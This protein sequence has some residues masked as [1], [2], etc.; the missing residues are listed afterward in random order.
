MK[1]YLLTFLLSLFAFISQAQISG[2]KNI[3]GDYA[4]L[5][6]AITALNAS[7]VGSGGVT[8]NVV[9]ANPQTAS[10]AAYQITAT[11]TAANP[12]NIQGNANT[13]TYTGT[14]SA[15]D[16][17][18]VLNGSDYVTV[19]NF[20]ITGDVTTE[21]GVALLTPV[22]NNGA[23]NNTI[24]NCTITLD[25]TNVASIAIYTAHHTNAAV[26][27]LT[28]TSVTGT[29]SNNKFYNNTVQNCYSGYSLTG[30]PAVAPYDLYDQQNEIGTTG[31]GRSQILNFGGGATQAQAVFTV[32]QNKLK[33][34]KTNI[35][36]TGGVNGTGI[37]YGIF[38]NTA[39]NA[40]V[41]IYNDTIT[42]VSIGTTNAMTA[43]NNTAGVTG[44]G[45]TV[46]IY[47]NVV[48]NCTYAT[49]TGATFRGISQSATATYT[50]I[51]NNKVI[52]NSLAGTAEFSGIYYSGSSATLVLNVNINDNEVSNNSKTGTAGILYMISA[53]ANTN[54]TNCYNN[55]VFNNNQNVASTGA[56]YGYYNFGAGYNE[57]VY[58]NQVYNCTGGT[59]ETVALYARS[60][61]GPTIKTVN[62][63]TIYG[64]TG[65]GQV[66]AI[67]SDYATKATIYKNNIYNITSN[68]AATTASVYGIQTGINVNTK[69]DIYNNFISEL[70]APVSTSADAVYGLWLQAGVGI[71]QIN[72]YHNTV[73]LNATSTSAT[74]FGTAVAFLNANP[75]SIDLRNN[76]LVNT[77]TPGPTGGNTVVISRAVTTLS[78]YNLLSG[79]NC[80]YAGIP[81]ANKL[82]FRD[83]TNNDQTLQAFKDRVNPRDQSSFTEL[84]PFINVA[85]SPYNLHLAGTTQCE[86]GGQPITIVTT[87][88]D[89]NIRNVTTPDVGA[90]E[91]TGTMTDIASPN[92][93]YS[94]L[95]NDIIA[96]SRTVNLFA[97]ITDPSAINIT[98]GTNPRL[99]YK[100]KTQSNTYNDNTSAT[101]GWKYVEASNA[102]SAFSF[103]IDYTKLLTGAVVAA[104]TI[105]YF[106]TAQDLAGT[107]LVGLNAGAFTTQPTSVN[108]AAVNFPLLNTINQYG[109]SGNT[110]AGTINVGSAE[111]ITSL[112]NVGGLFQQLKAGV[113]TAD[114]TVNITSDLLLENGQFALVNWNESGAGKYSMTFMP[115]AATVRTIQGLSSSGALI[116]LDSA[117][118]VTFDG[119][120][121]GAGNYIRIRNTNSLNPAILLVNDAQNNTIRNCII[122]SNNTNNATVNIS[123]AINIGNSNIV[124]GSGNDNN[125]ITYNEIR[126]RSDV[127]GTPAI[128]IFSTGSTGSLDLF[129]SNNTISNN[130]IHDFFSATLTV[131]SGIQLGL[132]NTNFN[133]D[134]NSIY[135]TT[136]RVYTTTNVSTRGIFIN[137]S[138]SVNNIG[139]YNIRKN[140]IGGTAPLCGLNG[141]YWTLSS[142]GAITNLFNGMTVATGLLPTV[143]ADNV[144]KNIDYT[145]AA[146]AAATSMFLTLSAN[147][148]K[149]EVNNNQIGAPTGNDSLKLTFNTNGGTNS[150]CFVAGIIAFNG[151]A[152]TSNVTGNKIGG[153]SI[154]GSTTALVFTQLVQFQGTPTAAANI[155]NNLIGS[156]TTANSVQVNLSANPQSFIIGVRT[157]HSTPIVVG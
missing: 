140:Y 87:D 42:V 75:V 93:Q 92:I 82:I 21:W 85:S 131:Q 76:I 5:A 14:A 22:A 11:G 35:N 111:T 60:G 154:A 63:N 4:D 94:L 44:A 97:K 157:T 132:G 139:G 129:N 23:K 10:A 138:S 90:D 152:S 3:P 62:T 25:K 149:F 84:P 65:G 123:G 121:A 18:F 30:F 56:T 124:N 114:V 33:V 127:V 74:T 120:F 96:T 43:I 15:L 46:N 16:A 122:E 64:I 89:G 134:S 145:S 47:N 20:V 53:S 128:G 103:T 26:T 37:L 137:Q 78:N 116:R 57:N 141:N 153:I 136:A 81:A 118:R 112:T 148:G 104:D 70:K 27:A 113:V 142:T 110:F 108:L 41:D 58:N 91:F 45:N 32:S 106:V 7:G 71:G 12:I 101:D 109:I 59:G 125:V 17:V 155:S 2:I 143:I 28:V 68:A 38:T 13:I 51:Y 67:W 48:Q 9:A 147:N 80:L 77:S 130:N 126:D 86:S 119:R 98:A 100:K 115:S 61:S 40:D 146:P 6:T 95:S 54:T 83:G 150:T 73:Y 144:I 34:F 50:N 107:P 135:Q 8:L 99:Y 88:Y 105:Q 55:I 69:V 151:T 72:A 66:G 31:I 19:D 49:S 133:I 24:Q 1:K 36:S 39:L 156:T 52:N 102:T 29:N 79:N 117:D